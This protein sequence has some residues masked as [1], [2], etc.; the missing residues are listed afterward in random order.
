MLKH[1]LG[2][3]VIS[4][5]DVKLGTELTASLRSRYVKEGAYGTR[6]DYNAPTI[7]KT[8]KAAQQAL[9]HAVV[10]EQGRR[11]YIIM[12]VVGQWEPTAEYG[13]EDDAAK[14]Q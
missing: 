5:D 7:Y 9:K 4:S 8:L 10:T 1:S 14:A 2:W 6:T 13:Y 3:I 11:G 12:R